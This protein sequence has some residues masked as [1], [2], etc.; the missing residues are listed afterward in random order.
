M[1]D[2]SHVRVGDLDVAYRLEG[3]EGRPVL[4]LMHGILTDHRMWDA[5]VDRLGETFG[6]LR[7]D[8]PGHGGSSAPPPL[9]TMEQLADDAVGLLDALQ[10]RQVHLIGTSL[11]GM[12]GQQV[13]ARHPSRLLSLTLANTAAQQAAPAAWDERIALARRSG[14]GALADPTLQRWFPAAFLEAS[15]AEAARLR[16][17]L[18]ATTVDGYA[19]CAQAVRDLDQAHLLPKITVPTLVVAGSRDTAIAPADTAKIAAG[20]PGARLVHIDAGH[21]AAVEKPAVFCADWRQFLA[22]LGEPG[23]GAGA[24]DYRA[25]GPA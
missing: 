8:L 16:A 10:L 24:W 11:G 4:L 13:G 21:L 20:V 5:L 9:Y 19:G 17:I 15:P 18:C 3:A 22:H 23:T 12:I 25:L 6:I 7:Y 2:L 14:V 1:S